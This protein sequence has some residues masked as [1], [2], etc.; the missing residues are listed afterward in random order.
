MTPEHS[1]Y[2]D[3]VETVATYRRRGFAETLMQRML[4]DAAAAG[5]TESIL[6]A[7]PMGKPLYQKLGYAEQA[8]IL[9][10]TTHE[11][12]SA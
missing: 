4:C 11:K 3:D 10:L 9:V 5:A 6:S 8:V 7:S 12:E 1:A 2:I